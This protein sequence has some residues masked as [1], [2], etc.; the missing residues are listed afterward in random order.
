MIPIKRLFVVAGF[1]G[2]AHERT[3]S[4]VQRRFEDG[5]HRFVTRPYPA[6]PERRAT[7]VETLVHDTVSLIFGDEGAANFCRRQ[8]QPC[9]LDRHRGKQKMRTCELAKGEPVACARAR[10]QLIVV[11][12]ADRVFDEVLDRLGRATLILRLD[13]TQLPDEDALKAAIDAFEP[14]AADIA[15]AVNHR[16][17]SLYAPLVPDR[18]FQRLAPA[19][20]SADVQADLAAFRLVMARYH[21]ALYRANFINPKKRGIRGAYMLDDEVAFQQDHLHKSVQILGEA[22]RRDGFHLLNAYHVYGVRTDP[23]FHFDVMKEGGVAIG[24]DFADILDG[25]PADKAEPHLNITP[26][27]RMV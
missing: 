7:H 20:I 4:G 13:G 6:K 12:C 11:I 26:C 27:D 22:S 15:D 1:D 21:Q 2:A 10:P 3:V 19:R 18:N 24:R 5:T 25:R 23:G 16:S 17:K 14:I 8:D 9:A